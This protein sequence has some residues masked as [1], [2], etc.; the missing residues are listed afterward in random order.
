MRGDGGGVHHLCVDIAS[1]D[2][3]PQIWVV[4]ILQVEG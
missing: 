2:R 3:P 1:Q 4:D